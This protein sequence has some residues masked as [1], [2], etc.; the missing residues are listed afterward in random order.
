MSVKLSGPESTRFSIV[1]V[2]AAKIVE[3]D[4]VKMADGAKRFVTVEEF[5][6]RFVMSPVEALKLVTN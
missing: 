3:V 2:V 6:V 1:A 5:E 4:C